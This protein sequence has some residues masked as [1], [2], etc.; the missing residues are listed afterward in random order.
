MGVCKSIIDWRNCN[1]STSLCIKG[2]AHT[3]NRLSLQIETYSQLAWLVSSFSFIFFCLFVLFYVFVLLISVSF[4][5]RD[6]NM[7]SSP[8]FQDNQPFS[9]FSCMQEKLL[10]ILKK[11]FGFL[12]WRNICWILFHWKHVES[13][14]PFNVTNIGVHC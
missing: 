7:T 12:N 13:C 14:Q 2:R 4:W 5:D 3:P 9:N 11:R 6:I 8:L 1:Q 10:L